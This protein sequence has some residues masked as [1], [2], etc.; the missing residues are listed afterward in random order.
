MT[1]PPWAPFAAK[2][3]PWL[4]LGAKIAAALGFAA[5]ADL[6]VLYAS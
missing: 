4:L 6:V 3:G 5:A 2:A 1:I